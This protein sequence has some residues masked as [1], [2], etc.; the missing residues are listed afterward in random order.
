MRPSTQRLPDLAITSAPILFVLLWSTGFIFTRLGLP[1]IEPMT[2]LAVRMSAVVVLMTIIAVVGGARLPDKAGIG[3]SFVAGLLVHG[4]YLGG[5]FLAI[6]Q[7]VPAGISALIPGLQP[8]LTSTIANRFMGEKVSPLQWAGLVLG[9]VGVALVLHDRQMLAEASVLGWVASV[10]SLIGITLG[11]L[12]QKRFSGGIDWRSG[13]TIQY[14]GVAVAFWLIAF[15][16]ETRVIHWTGELIVAL[17]WLVVVLSV[18]TI[19]LMYWLIRRSA[20]TRFASLF[21]LVPATTALMAYGL[22]GEKLDALSIF[23]MVVCAAGV[24]IV[25][26]GA[27]AQPA[28]ATSDK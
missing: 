16:F 25:N 1:Y 28:A 24:L 4:V 15:A 27:P 9:L 6:S 12:Y 11:S 2:F 23:G 5:V 7:G 18:A 26:R 19:G 14:F 17:T 20:A 22:F 3:H 21:Y 10:V 8:I 13:N